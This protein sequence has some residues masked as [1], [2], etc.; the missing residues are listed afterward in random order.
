M[1][2]RGSVLD[3]VSGI[4]SGYLLVADPGPDR[5]AAPAHAAGE[6]AHVCALA[7]A[8]VLHGDGAG[9][10]VAVEGGAEHA[11][12]GVAFAHARALAIGEVEVVWVQQAGRGG[13]VVGLGLGLLSQG[14][15]QVGRLVLGRVGAIARGR[16]DVDGR[17]GSHV[18]EAAVQLRLLGE[19][20]EAAVA[21]VFEK[22]V[23]AGLVAGHKLLGLAVP[24]VG[25][26]GTRVLLTT[27]KMRRRW[28]F[29][30]SADG[31]A[32]C[33]GFTRRV[34][35]RWRLLVGIQL[36]GGRR[37]VEMWQWGNNA[38]GTATR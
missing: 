37:C 29:D 31:G 8:T 21:R 34:G 12:R 2:V 13:H 32:R 20:R 10:A 38:S 18:G 35:E 25:E 28:L 15:R 30:R 33:R 24:E 1:L 4:L 27:A 23:L 36:R 11:D 6:A 16:L 3:L 19:E 9:A 5:V 22:D 17:G 26:T 7:A 14:R